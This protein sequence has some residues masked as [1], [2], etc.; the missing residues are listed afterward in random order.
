M[1]DKEAIL[2]RHSVRSYED[3]KIDEDGKNFLLPFAK[4]IGYVEE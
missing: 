1:T 2:M 4:K 3:K